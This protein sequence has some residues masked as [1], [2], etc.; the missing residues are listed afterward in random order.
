M[1]YKWAVKSTDDNLLM[2]MQYLPLHDNAIPKN[3]NYIAI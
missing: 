1:W 2:T 3:D